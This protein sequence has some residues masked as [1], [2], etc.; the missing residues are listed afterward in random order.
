MKIKK[1]C[2]EFFFRQT[3]FITFLFSIL[4]KDNIVRN[5]KFN[6]YWYIFGRGFQIFNQNLKILHNK[7]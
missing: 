4:K 3:N 7:T 5:S 6:L 1:S 2:V